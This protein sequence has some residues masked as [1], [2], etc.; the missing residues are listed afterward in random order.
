MPT[1]NDPLAPAGV[2]AEL[3]AMKAFIE[4]TARREKEAAG[5]L[6]NS[7]VAARRGV[8]AKEEALRVEQEQA[9]AELEARHADE[10]DE[11]EGRHQ[12]RLAWI[13]EKYHAARKALTD[14]ITSDRDQ[15]VGSVQAEIMRRQGELKAEYERASEELV[16]LRGRA[17]ED[18]A[19]V[20]GMAAEARRHLRGFKPW[21]SK[22]LAG[23]GV[24]IEEAGEGE[25][26]A[27]A[28][29]A[30]DRVRALPLAKVFRFVPLTLLLLLAVGVPAGVSGSPGEISSWWLTAAIAVGGVMVIYLVA[31]ATVWGP[32]KALAQA[33]QRVRF[34]G[35]TG[36]NAMIERV[37]GLKEQMQAETEKL[38]GDLS[39]TLRES[40]SASQER[41][42]RGREK[43]EQQL[44]R[45]P[46]VEERLHRRRMARV[47]AAH[48]ERMAGHE[49]RLRRDA[50]ML[51][52]GRLEKVA[53]SEAE[54]DKALGAI[55]EEWPAQ[56]DGRRSR[57]ESLVDQRAER[58]PEWS[59]EFL[60]NWEPP[61]EA[62]SVIPFGTY[63]TSPAALADPCPEGDRFSLPETIE[64]PLALSFPDHGS[65]LLEGDAREA[66]DVMNAIVLRLLAT[67]PPGRV[68]FTFIDAVGLGRDHAGL[69][70]LA[71]YEDTL[72]HGRIWT[73]SQQIEERLA[74]LNE[75]V[76]KVIQMYLRNEYATITEYNEQAGTIA[77]KYQFVVISGL[78]T[79]FSETAMARLRSLAASGARCGV[80]LLVQLEQPLADPAL[81]AELR[82]A[83]LCL[84]QDDGGWRWAGRPGEV[85]L[86]RAPE[87]KLETDLV[88]RFGK[89][90]VD[91]NRIEVPFSSI[92]PEGEW[93]SEETG[94]ELR[95]PIGRTGA[96]KLQYLAMGKGTR[97]HALI[98]GKTGSGKSTLFHVMI[99]N[100]ALHC[101]PEEV[102][103]YL[104]DF[105]KGVEF[106]CYGSKRLPH[107]RVVAIESDRE[108]GLSVLHR[109]DEE[110]RRRG[111]LFRECGAQDVAG[112]RKA[113]GQ[114]LPRTLLL[115][116]EFQEFFTE[117][118]GVG[119]EASLL[120]DRIVR[121][122]RAFGIHA[123][124]G[125]QTLGGAY[126]L[127]RATL[128]QMVIRIALQC[129]EAD[130]YL[131]MDDDNPAPRLLTR[132]G[133]GIYNDNA[134]AVAANSPF[135]T[136]WLSEEERNAKLEE[137]SQ[138]ASQRGLRMPA[139]VVFEG[140]A[141]AD[142][143]DNEPL[144]E[145]VAN[146][147]TG[148][149]EAAKAWL[150]APNSI[151]GPTA[152]VFRRQSGA[153]L[154]AVG[155]GEER[156][157]ALMGGALLS[158]DA[159]FP[160]GG[161]RFVVLDP[162]GADGYLASVVGGLKHPGEVHLPG[163]LGPV[164][165]DLAQRLEGGGD[166][167]VF[168]FIRDLQ[169]FKGLRQ[170]EDFSFS[171]DEPSSG[172]ASP[173][174]VFLELISEGAPAGLHLLASVDTWNN[175][176]RWIP[177]KAMADFQMRV[178]YQMSAND[179]A[180]LIDS[181]AA[182]NLGLHRALLYD[183]SLGT[184]E[185]FRPYARPESADLG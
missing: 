40:D 179:S 69:M 143:R 68:A 144:A 52:A 49:E 90:S 165:D 126:T 16:A 63:R 153:N 7:M 10:R 112:Y 111:E 85:L 72:I 103:F 23:Q 67:H 53:E 124:L 74:E 125:S 169:R 110:L 181:P 4:E 118:D 46:A 182:G 163:E 73:Q 54:A 94:G 183:E 164:M 128:G 171:F 70:H 51:E 8:Q 61:S 13:E 178:L 185:T 18:M 22:K 79:G 86:D 60:E 145:L 77:E 45:L 59:R 1:A 117:D 6:T 88:H 43:L 55:A 71:D 122:G 57:L 91:S 33:L 161:A 170:E 135:Q 158:L 106:K 107:A 89:A 14:Q 19:K 131:I 42:R 175:V 127:A 150:G 36:V 174:K 180:A 95:V 48:A 37:R 41:I 139:P 168:V 27:A 184:V 152:A 58:F 83:C 146:P 24:R 28:D 114:P 149:P 147:P 140:N 141:P 177:R 120:L 87:D 109:V 39:E 155:Q 32:A 31:L 134:G 123:I 44:S 11:V 142:L 76:E 38:R 50:E 157:K 21:V 151:K 5:V 82:R 108:F 105:K 102:E 97:Q 101:S 137:L 12:G 80:F 115:I 65:L 160:D 75:H 159:Q 104:V 132:P 62:P 2:M 34:S 99:T 138:M 25:L 96:K 148:K 47:E 167:E 17:E 64:A 30:L 173:A 20:A 129:N 136:V 156:M 66:A 133:E 100:L 35:A 29:E 162:E 3:D 154:L 166:E 119:Q 92:A 81:D 78:P 15:R 98:A 26:L 130:A 84:K 113:T 9:R 56:V 116:D 93:W 172:G 121:Q 176:G